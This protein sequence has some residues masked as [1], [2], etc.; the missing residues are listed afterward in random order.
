M[1]GE[2]SSA[3]A[4]AAQWSITSAPLIQRRTPSFD[5]VWKRFWFPPGPRELLAQPK[6]TASVRWRAGVPETVTLL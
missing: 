1:T 3:V 5:A 4:W 6:L 2:S